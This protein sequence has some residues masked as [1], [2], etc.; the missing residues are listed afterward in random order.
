MGKIERFLA[1]NG[2]KKKYFA[3]KIG[4]SAEML[5]HYFKNHNGLPDDLSKKGLRELDRH[6]RKVHR[7]V[8]RES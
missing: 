2:I 4:I 1:N 5:R 3:K 7:F 8:K 6:S